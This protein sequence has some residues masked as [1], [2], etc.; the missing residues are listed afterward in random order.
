MRSACHSGQ[1]CRIHTIRIKDS[2]RH[3][4]DYKIEAVSPG[5]QA[6]DF[7]QFLLIT[8]AVNLL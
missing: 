4:H 8:S 6:A 3:F 2:A 7:P 5:E 1:V